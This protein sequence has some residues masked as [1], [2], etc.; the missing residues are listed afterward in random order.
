MRDSPR[1]KARRRISV[2]GVAVSG[3]T[4]NLHNGYSGRSRDM[5]LRTITSDEQAAA[6]KQ[7]GH[8][9]KTYSSGNNNR[10]SEQI[11]K[12]IDESCFRTRSHHHKPHASHRVHSA[13]NFGIM[14]DGPHPLRLTC[15]QTDLSDLSCA[16][17]AGVS[18]ESAARLSESD[19][20]IS[21]VSLLTVIRKCLSRSRFRSTSCRTP[22]GKTRSVK[23][24]SDPR[25]TRDFRV[26]AD[27][28][29]AR[30]SVAPEK[31]LTHP[32]P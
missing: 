2:G 28:L 23:S 27:S 18:I 19:D 25:F 15:P 4:G 31:K 13:A 12:T 8:S 1:P 32:A 24:I 14:L 6:G 11:P 7:R 21:N 29:N 26:V 20:Q 30:R 17:P 9:P 3:V 5:F 10:V 16:P 22:V